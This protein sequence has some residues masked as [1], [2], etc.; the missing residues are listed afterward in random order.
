MVMAQG[1]TVVTIPAP[2]AYPNGN[3]LAK[4]A[5]NI[6]IISAN[7]FPSAEQSRVLVETILI[8]L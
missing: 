3:R 4:L 8:Q 6:S 1:L 2:K 7:L 5:T